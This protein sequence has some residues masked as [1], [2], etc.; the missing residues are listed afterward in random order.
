[1][2]SNITIDIWDI[3]GT[4]DVSICAY[5]AEGAWESPEYGKVPREEAE[6]VIDKIR[7]TATDAE[8]KGR[9]TAIL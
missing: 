8:I 7:E 1:M 9:W 5:D 2:S 3:Q 4:D 6:Q